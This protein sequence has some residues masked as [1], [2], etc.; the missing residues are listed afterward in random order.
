[1][2]LETLTL[3]TLA[4]VAALGALGATLR[5]IAVATI[6]AAS[7]GLAGIAVV[8]IAGS[9]LA[10]A[11]IASPE[12][13][14]NIALVLGLCGSMTTFSTLAVQLAP[15]GSSLSGVRWIGLALLHAVGSVLAAWLAYSAV[16]LWG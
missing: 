9:A 13:P 1:M 3:E 4:L 12:S 15:G 6:A 5:Y 11:L 10:G 8:N 14:W 2:T 7:G 16:T